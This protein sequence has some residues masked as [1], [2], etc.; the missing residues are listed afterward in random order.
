MTINGKRDG[1]LTADIRGAGK[2]AGLKQ[3]RANALLGEVTAAVKR[4]PEFAARAGLADDVVEKI[5]NAHR[6]NLRG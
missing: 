6:L 5:Q 1:F 3:G 2:S 4:W